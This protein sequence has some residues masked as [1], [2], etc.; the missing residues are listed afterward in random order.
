MNIHVFG[1][2]VYYEDEQGLHITSVDEGEPGTAENRIL[3]LE[4][5][6]IE[7]K[8]RVSD[9]E[10]GISPVPT[11]EPPEDDQ[12]FVAYI[13]TD[14][15]TLARGICG[16]NNAG[17]PLIS[18]CIYESPR[19]KWVEGDMLFASVEETQAD[20]GDM[21]VELQPGENGKNDVPGPKLFVK[22]GDL[23]LL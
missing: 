11:P 4:Q 8:N 10:E 2:Y 14:E 6:V 20:G 16:Y 17:K 15:K 18:N 23:D 5:A 1:N 13:V 22:R 12:E 3:A 7:L 9:L 19:I 21:Y